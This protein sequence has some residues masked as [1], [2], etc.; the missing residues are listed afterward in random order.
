MLTDTRMTA[1][2]FERLWNPSRPL[3]G[4]EKGAAYRTSREDAL[5]KKFIQTHPQRA[6]RLLVLDYDGFGSDWEVLSQVYDDELLPEPNYMTLN[7]TTGGV[8]VGYFLTSSVGSPAG[9]SYFNNTF[10]GLKDVSGSDLSFVGSKTR[11]P[12]HPDQATTW[13]RGETYE[14]AELYKFV[15][16]KPAGWYKPRNPVE[17]NGSRHQAL[18]NKLRA[19]AYREW[20]KDSYE[21]RL[22]L[23]AQR[24][25]AEFDTPMG[26]SEVVNTMNAVERW[27]APRFSWAEFCAIQSRRANKRWG[28]QGDA[29]IE[30]ILNLIDAG[31]KAKDVAEI[32]GITIDAAYK[33]IERARD[34]RIL[35]MLAAGLTAEDIAENLDMT[36]AKALKAVKKVTK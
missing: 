34:S 16:P 3:A 23:E 2:D 20:H 9:L 1:E 35:A 14:L 21:V 36:L 28:G 15:K 8:H 11:N 22:M 26:L 29:T 19:W 4:N 5:T 13:M 31:L 30:A 6:K 17:E 10:E 7:P 25:N 32:R 33:A 12:L 24:L 18:F 27:I